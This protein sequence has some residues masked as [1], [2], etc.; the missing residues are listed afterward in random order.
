[1]REENSRISTPKL[2]ARIF[3][4]I[5]IAAALFVAGGI[6]VCKIRGEVFFFGNKTA[7]YV[8][9][10]SMEPTI[11]ARSFIIVERVDPDEVEVGDVIMF[12][13]DDPGIRGE[14]NTH[15]VIAISPDR[16]TFYTKG[17]N[18]V[19]EDAY[20]P[21][22]DDIRARYVGNAD[23]LNRF[24]DWFLTKTGLIVTLIAILVLCLGAYLP[25]VIAAMQTPTEADNEEKEALIRQKIGEEVARLKE[26][27]GK[28]SD[29]E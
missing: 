20:P 29:K 15:E 1:M 14:F 21:G 10:G 7:V 26:Q 5:C 28:D 19:R 17:T 13:S 23:L 12:R 24:F 4:A 16:E 3:T 27:S 25:G 9:S 8:V 6:A 18:N 2:L 11:K 22:A